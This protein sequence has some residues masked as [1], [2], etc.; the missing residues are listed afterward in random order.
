MN[1]R[2]TS[3]KETKLYSQTTKKNVWEK[4]KRNKKEKKI[5]YCCMESPVADD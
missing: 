3:V 4:G 5:I 2:I 1:A